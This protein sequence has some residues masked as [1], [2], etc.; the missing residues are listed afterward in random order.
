MRVG[1]NWGPWQD[2]TIPWQYSRTPENTRMIQEQ[3]VLANSFF[4]PK[5][6]QKP[7]C[8][9]SLCLLVASSRQQLT[10]G[11]LWRLAWQHCWFPRSIPVAF[12]RPM[13]LHPNFIEVAF[14]SQSQILSKQQEGFQRD[15]PN[16][17]GLDHLWQLGEWVYYSIHIREQEVYL[18]SSTWSGFEIYPSHVTHFLADYNDLTD[19]TWRMSWQMPVC[20]C[21]KTHSFSK[22]TPISF[23]LDFPRTADQRVYHLGIRAGEVANRIVKKKWAPFEMEKCL[24]TVLCADNG[25]ISL[26]SESNRFLLGYHSSPIRPLFR[27]RIL[28]YHWPLQGYTHLYCK[29]WH[30]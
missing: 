30:G 11:N 17:W 16:M 23:D 20:T 3:S 12:F 10:T 8:G 28:D 14:C 25:R 21:G 22:A 26:E 1:L 4:F 15:Y 29:Y 18:I 2:R 6:L 13:S 24:L 7:H 5:C 9:P 19:S 27:A